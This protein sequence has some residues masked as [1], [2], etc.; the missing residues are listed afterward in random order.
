[1]D[2]GF[3][4]GSSVSISNTYNNERVRISIGTCINL[5]IVLIYGP[6]GVENYI[7]V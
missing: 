5:S 1:M 3:I 6:Y 2:E 4:F 7:V